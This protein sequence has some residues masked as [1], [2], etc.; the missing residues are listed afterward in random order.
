M[1]WKSVMATLILTASLLCCPDVNA[2]QMGQ[3]QKDFQPLSGYVVDTVKGHVLID[4][5]KSSPVSPGDLFTISARGKEIVHPVDKKVLGHVKSVQALLQVVKVEE[6]FSYAQPLVGAESVKP[7]QFVRRFG[8]MK[9]VF[10][11][12]TGQDEALYKELR[13]AVPHLLWKNFHQ[14]QKEKPDQPEPL[15][16]HPAI[17]LYFV[18]KA[19][20]IEVRGPYFSLI[21]A[22]SLD[23]AGAAGP[24]PDTEKR[25]KA[26]KTRQDIQGHEVEYQEKFSQL[27]TI[28][29]LEEPVIMADFLS[30]S[31]AQ[32]MAFSNGKSICVATVSTKLKRQASARPDYPG[33]VLSLSWWAPEDD[34]RL[35]VVVNIWYNSSIQ[36]AVFAYS[37]GK[38]FCV[39]DR[40]AKLLSAFDTDSDCMPETLL[41]QH[42][43]VNTIF[44]RRIWEGRVADAAIRWTQTDISFPRQFQVTGSTLADVT[45]DGSAEI[46][47]IKKNTL[48]IY[49]HNQ[50]LYKSSVKVG[51]SQSSLLYKPEISDQNAVSNSVVFE[52][53]PLARDIDH[54]GIQEIVLPA[55][56]QGFWGSITVQSDTAQSKILVLDYRQSWFGQGT[57]GGFIDGSLQGLTITD[58][59]AYLVSL[60]EGGSFSSNGRSLLSS[61]ALEFK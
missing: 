33:R 14:S 21:N 31:G 57:L 32:L 47:F 11:D 6:E 37:E 38:L 4:F 19:S 43:D 8:H 50:L 30:K 59:T 49:D 2:A 45:G 3:I 17:Q 5:G 23:S 36:S 16:G 58:A 28:A 9:A 26:A 40:M 53:S 35:Y 10:W 52:L 1:A 34:E 55:C 18:K 46:I 51:G 48:F 25:A 54:D 7:G 56:Q 27:H 24:A 60:Q 41:A 20:K 39:Q 61:F 15:P 29:S 44:G 22:Y 42:Y 13:S 12:Y